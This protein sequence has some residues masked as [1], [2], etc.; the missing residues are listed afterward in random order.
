MKQRRYG[1]KFE[2]Q[3]YRKGIFLFGCN[4]NSNDDYGS[5]E[6]ET[7]ICIYLFKIALYI[8]KFH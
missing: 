6:R 3:K 5:E 4:F 2:L 1:W 8:G 7:Y